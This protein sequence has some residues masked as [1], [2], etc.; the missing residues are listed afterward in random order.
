MIV[1]LIIC[2][3][4]IWHHK[5]NSTVDCSDDSFEGI[6]VAEY[7][8]GKKQSDYIKVKFAKDD[9][10]DHPFTKEKAEA[11]CLELGAHLWKVKHR[12]EFLKV[13]SLPDAQNKAFWLNH[14]EDTVGGDGCTYVPLKSGDRISERTTCQGDFWAVCVKRNCIN[15][16]GEMPIYTPRGEFSI[17]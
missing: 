8:G 6:P 15:P 3:I 11:K 4:L 7:R 5:S 10:D 2:G 1:L 17:H 12:N 9:D 13:L 14:D 16:K